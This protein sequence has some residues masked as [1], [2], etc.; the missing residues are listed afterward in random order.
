MAKIE[1][2]YQLFGRKGIEWSS[3][4]TFNTEGKDVTILEPWQLDYKLKNEYRRV[5]DDGTITPIKISYSNN[6]NKDKQVK[7]GTKK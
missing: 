2:R 7:K 5:E 1:K 4:F 6:S 3:W